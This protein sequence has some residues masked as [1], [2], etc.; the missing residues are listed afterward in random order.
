MGQGVSVIATRFLSR[1]LGAAE[2]LAGLELGVRL[3]PVRLPGTR[4]I[5]LPGTRLERLPGKRLLG[6]TG[7]RFL[8][9]ECRTIRGGVRWRRVGAFAEPFTRDER[10]LADLQL[11]TGNPS[12]RQRFEDVRRHAGGEVDDRKLIHDPNLADPTSNR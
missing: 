2:L 12:F 5:R 7:E 1:R 3:G 6:F 9:L 4:P 8:R 10:V 11:L